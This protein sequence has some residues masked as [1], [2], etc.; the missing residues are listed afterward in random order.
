ML[1][2]TLKELDL[3]TD[4]TPHSL[5]S[6][7]FKNERLS[8]ELSSKLIEFT[9]SIND[10]IIKVASKETFAKGDLVKEF[11]DYTKTFE[12]IKANIT[13]E[14]PDKNGNMRF[15]PEEY[16]KVIYIITYQMIKYLDLSQEQVAQILNINKKNYKDRWGISPASDCKMKQLSYK[17]TLPIDSNKEELITLLPY[18]GSY[19][20]E[21]SIS[22]FIGVSNHMSLFTN[23]ENTNKN[24]NQK[25]KDDGSRFYGRQFY[26]NITNLEELYSWV[27]IEYILDNNIQVKERV[28]KLVCTQDIE[29]NKEFLEFLLTC[30]VEIKAENLIDND[31]KGFQNKYRSYL[32]AIENK[33]IWLD[34]LDNPDMP[35]DELM[36]DRRKWKPEESIS[37][38]ELCNKEINKLDKKINSYIAVLLDWINIDSFETE[39]TTK[40][41][42][43]IV[44]KYNKKL[45]D[46]KPELFEDKDAFCAMYLITR[47]FNANGVST[48]MIKAFDEYLA[49]ANFTAYI[50]RYKNDYISVLKDGVDINDKLSLIEKVQALNNQITNRKE[51][52][53]VARAAIIIDADSYAVD[54][55]FVEEVSSINNEFYLII[56]ST[57]ELELPSL[58][59]DKV[60]NTYI[61]ASEKEQV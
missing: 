31:Y 13:A 43:Y 46:F 33:K 10:H 20:A 61:Y 12:E 36:V 17:Y 11:E 4:V 26:H 47:Y 48:E 60:Q 27:F 49:S 6:L 56:L 57:K 50:N 5:K 55:A 1:F 42:R 58:I 23:L 3:I 52:R 38:E 30:G 59:K 8:D 37:H 45:E 28:K 14:I 32:D 2:N 41:Y 24:S 7:S 21:I 39:D 18:I 51:K 34:V 16:V 35:Y 54:K 25:N 15:T 53:T 40:I 22:Y 19:L 44:D 9:R 29:M